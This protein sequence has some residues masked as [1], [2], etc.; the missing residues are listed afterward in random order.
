[1]DSKKHGNLVDGN[2]LLFFLGKN[3]KYLEIFYKNK[4]VYSA[5]DIVLSLSSSDSDIIK[6]HKGK[7]DI[8]KK[9]MED[10]ISE[11]IVSLKERLYDYEAQL[12]DI[13]N[14]IEHLKIQISQFESICNDDDILKNLISSV[15][16][17]K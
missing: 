3:P 16:R 9:E 2:D 15:N 13:N 5:V 4:Y 7:G 14:K 11:Q 10:Y 6:K 8:T 1:M 12:S 17:E